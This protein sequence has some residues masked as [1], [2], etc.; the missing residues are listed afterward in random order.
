MTS[1]AAKTERSRFSLKRLTKVGEAL[2]II[3]CEVRDEDALTHAVVRTSQ[4]WSARKFA[5]RR[6]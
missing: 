1:S 2:E 3:D 4:G 5:C 6:A